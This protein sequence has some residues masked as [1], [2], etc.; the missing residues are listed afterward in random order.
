VKIV[1]LFMIRIKPMSGFGNSL[2]QNGRDNA[3]S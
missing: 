3:S 2:G 1:R